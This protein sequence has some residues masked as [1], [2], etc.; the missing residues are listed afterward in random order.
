MNNKIGIGVI[1]CNREDF[2]RKTINALPDVETIVVVNDGQSYPSDAYPTK[3]K[4]VL[5]HSR[6]KSVGISKNEALRY[7]IQDGCQHLFLVEDDML[8]TNPEVCRAYIKGAEASGIW[9]LNFGYHGPANK[10]PDGTK[11]PRTTVEYEPGIEL[12]FNPNCVGSFSYYLKGVIKTIGY[13]DERFINAWEHCEHTYRTI[14][15]GLHP[16]WWWFA[17]LANSDEYIQELAS[18]EVNSVIRKTDEWRLNMQN[19]AGWFQIKHGFTPTAI[20]DTHPDVVIKKLE[21][22]QMNYSKKML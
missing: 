7:L 17:D 8:I 15:E 18:S 19:G 3:V 9:H 22:I 11:N 14:K 1:T 20:P 16:P 12:A 10:K 6:N 5:Q 2:F 13:M 21:E 4:E